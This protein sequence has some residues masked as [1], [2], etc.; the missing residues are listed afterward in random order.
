MRPFYF[1]GVICIY[2]IE[3][4]GMG[5]YIPGAQKIPLFLS[6][7]IFLSL[8]ATDKVTE[9]LRHGQAKAILVFLIHTILSMSYA[10]VG[11]YALNVV[12]IQVGYVIV[13][14]ST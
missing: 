6:A 4:I 13:F 14:I 1:W 2:A 3:Y 5:R 11:S 10:Y 12:K 9:V 8:V 7:V